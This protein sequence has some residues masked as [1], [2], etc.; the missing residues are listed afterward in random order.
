MSQ[1]IGYLHS[2]FNLICFLVRDVTSERCVPRFFMVVESLFTIHYSLFTI[3]YSLYC[4][5][6]RLLPPGGFATLR[7]EAFL[8]S[9]F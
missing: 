4:R 1:G 6:R 7:R 2:K 3:H 5:R 8:N 9:K